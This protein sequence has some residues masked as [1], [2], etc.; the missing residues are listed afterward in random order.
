M[1]RFVKWNENFKEEAVEIR[2]CILRVK[3]EAKFRELTSTS[4]PFTRF[5]QTCQKEVFYA[6]S[7]E[8]IASYIRLNRCVAF[9]KE[10]DIKEDEKIGTLIRPS[11]L[12]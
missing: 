10:F 12:K 4:A 7:D 11:R 5:C 9:H 2:N 8:E 6:E 1:I 3:C